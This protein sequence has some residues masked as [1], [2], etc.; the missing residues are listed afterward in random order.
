VDIIL[1]G[2]WYLNLKIR[3]LF[4]IKNNRAFGGLLASIIA[5][6]IYHLD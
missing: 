3:G 4:F 6:T 5:L 2:S 1:D